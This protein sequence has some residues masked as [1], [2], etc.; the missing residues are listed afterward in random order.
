[1]NLMKVGKIAVGIVVGYFVLSTLLSLLNVV[2]GFTIKIF[3][4]A[5]LVL[6]IMYLIKQIKN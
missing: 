3:I 1:M 5:A 2:L 4:I 6:G